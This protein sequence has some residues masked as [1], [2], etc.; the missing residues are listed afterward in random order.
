MR[1]RSR[2]VY[3]IG[4]IICVAAAIT[5]IKSESFALTLSQT[6]FSGNSNVTLSP[7]GTAF[8]IGLGDKNAE[9]H[10]LVYLNYVHNVHGVHGV[11]EPAPGYHI[12]TGEVK[13]AVPVGYWKLE[14]WTSNCIHSRNSMNFRTH[15]FDRMGVTLANCFRYYPPGWVAYC[16]V[17]GEKIDDLYFYMT[18]R[19]AATIGYL[20]S[21]TPYSTY[22]YLCPYDN[23]LE[24]EKPIKH[25][26]HCTSANRYRIRYNGGA[27]ALGSMGMDSFYY[28]S[29][30]KYEGLEVVPQ[31]RLSDCSYRR[32]GYVF[33]GWSLTAGGEAVFSD[34]EKWSNIQ[35]AVKAGE[36]ENDS[37]IDVYAV[38]QQVSSN[39][40]L[41][42]TGGKIGG[43]R[44]SLSLSKSYGTEYDIQVPTYEPL[45]I[46]F[47]ANGGSIEGNS[48]EVRSADRVFREWQIPKTFYGRTDGK[49]YVFMSG[50][51]GTTDTLTAI[52][53]VSPVF[54]P[55][56]VRSGYR[57][58]GWYNS[59]GVFVGNAD[60]YYTPVSSETLTAGWEQVSITLTAKSDLSDSVNGGKG[61]VDLT[62]KAAGTGYDSAYRVYKS[63]DGNSFV[64]LGENGV[65]TESSTESRSFSYSDGSEQTYTVKETG[66][67]SIVLTGAEGG[68]CGFNKGG[69]GGRIFLRMWLVKGQKVGIVCGGRGNGKENS[70]I[71]KS[72]LEAMY[73]GGAG[74][75][76]KAFGGGSGGG[77]TSLYVTDTGGNKYLV[78]A[79]GGGGGA[80][81]TEDG[82]AGGSRSNNISNG[83]SSDGAPIQFYRREFTEYTEYSSGG[84]GGYYP[85]KQGKTTYKRHVHSTDDPDCRF[86]QHTG[87]PIKGGG[88]YTIPEYSSKNISCTIECYSTG[89]HQYTC[90]NPGCGNTGTLE[91]YRE[92]GYYYGGCWHYTG[93]SGQPNCP[94]CGDNHGVYLS[95]GQTSGEYEIT[96]QVVTYSLG[97]GLMPGFNCR[98]D[99]PTEDTLDPEKSYSAGG[100]GNWVDRSSVREFA[101]VDAVYDTNECI[102]VNYGNGN[103]SLEIIISGCRADEFLDDIPAPDMAAPGEITGCLVCKKQ[104]RNL[105]VSWEAAKD[106][107]TPYYFKVD[108]YSLTTGEVAATSNTEKK[109]IVSGVTGYYV[110]EDTYGYTE[111]NSG[112]GSFTNRCE[113]ETSAVSGKTKYVHIAAVDKAGN[114]GKTTHIKID[115]DGDDIDICWDIYTEK[116]VITEGDNVLKS[117]NSKYYVKADGKTPFYLDFAAYMDGEARDSYQIGKCYFRDSSDTGKYICV[118]AENT[119]PKRDGKIAEN[120]ISYADKGMIINR[121]SYTEGYRSNDCGRI[122]IKQGFTAGADKDGYRLTLIPGA[123]ATSAN[124]IHETVASSVEKDKYNGLEIILDGKGPGITGLEEFDVKKLFIDGSARAKTVTVS[125]S[126]TGAGLDPDNSYLRIFNRDNACEETWSFAGGIGGKLSL[127]F[128][129]EKLE[130]LFYYGLFTIEVHAV[131]KV[132]NATDERIEGVG[133]DLETDVVR[134]LEKVDGKKI[135]ARGESGDL[136]VTSTGYVEYVEVKFPDELSEYDTVFDYRNNPELKKEEVLRFMIPLYDIPEGD[137]DFTI[138]VTAHKGEESLESHP[139]ISVVSVSGSVLDEIRT[140]LE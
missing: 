66:I 70:R 2:F 50:R 126:D 129:A 10:D 18:E 17:C 82:G 27:G 15:G 84:G 71:F 77:A 111:V 131:D 43:S 20:P 47:N 79:A 81:L 85:G 108:N 64:I 40:K 115:P 5:F 11:S 58:K 99:L 3:V 48:T 138:K 52:C 12:Y 92:Y 13:G 21:G 75:G 59:R 29:A 65:V 62:W 110:R 80:N 23:S 135:F 139:R 140:G 134:L 123:E 55:S 49:K 4:L 33:K 61:A 130:E 78:A 1:Y 60:E 100:G 132:G 114:V 87:N 51:Q 35:K 116:L 83:Y 103:A 41:Q 42:F 109:V 72:D 124:G 136:Y 14:H 107:G 76:G 32:T 120:S 98:S 30:E 122:L 53:G 68:G 113:I 9:K 22:F 101:V 34:G 104:G 105:R 90:Q 118:I 24:N 102:G 7:D 38:W 117:G 112:N 127:T 93:F 8:T 86:H 16:A 89:T 19:V 88:C 54:L 6:V 74:G 39:L 121:Y 96:E 106:N 94:K 125:A 128:T 36:L 45:K 46:T 67:Y 31:S 69:A 25:I 57:F 97:C 26:C 91:D 37:I 63:D 95:D 133:F 119:V 28:D 137:W 73:S 56:P 44:D